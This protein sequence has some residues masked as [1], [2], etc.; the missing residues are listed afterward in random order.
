[1]KKLYIIAG[2]NGAG[3]T[4]A[5]YTV[6]PEMLSCKEFV[7]ADEIAKGLSPFNPASVKIEAGRIMVGRVRELLEDGVDFAL[8]TT[9]STRSYVSLIKRAKAKGYYVTLVFFWLNDPQLAVNRVELRAA[10]GGHSIS[11]QV[12]R[13]RYSR[14]LHNLFNLYLELADYWIIVDNSLLSFEIIAEGEHSAIKTITNPV[15]YKLMQTYE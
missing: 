6:L 9:L 2:C 8:E 12:V 1:M 4:T 7:N 15:S 3:K 14:G 13:R 5:S 10:G 11:E